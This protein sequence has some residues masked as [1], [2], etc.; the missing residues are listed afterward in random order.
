MKL[1]YISMYIATLCMMACNKSGDAAAGY[2]KKAWDENTERY[3]DYKYDGEG[4]LIQASSSGMTGNT[5]ITYQY[6]DKRLSEVLFTTTYTVQSGM[7]IVR[8]RKILKYAD[9]GRLSEIVMDYD[10]KPT[11]SGNITRYEFV[12]SDGSEKFS[13]CKIYRENNGGEIYKWRVDFMYDARGNIRQYR[14]YFLVNDQWESHEGKSYTY[15]VVKNPYYRTGDPTDFGN[16]YSRDFWVESTSLGYANFE[17]LQVTRSY[18]TTFPNVVI[19]S[20]VQ[21]AVSTR[22]E[23]Y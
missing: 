2:L 14:N 22:Y 16:Y 13:S 15:S 10:G 6:A 18:K 3:N 8:Y 23:Y 1:L 7:D 19:Y 20:N 4:R 5:E 11:P 17:P 21:G 9:A 12:Y